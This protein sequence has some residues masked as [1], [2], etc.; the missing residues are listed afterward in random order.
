MNAREQC[1]NKTT[2]FWKQLGFWVQN[3]RGVVVAESEETVGESGCRVSRNT[4]GFDMIDLKY[5]HVLSTVRL[6]STASVCLD[7]TIFKFGA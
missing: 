5:T 2:V 1:G 7:Q 4:I 6:T 3:L